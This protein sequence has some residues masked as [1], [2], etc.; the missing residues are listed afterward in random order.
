MSP[1]V[2]VHRAIARAE[3]VLPGTP[4]PEGKRDPRWQAII[5]VG[6]F[7]RTHPDPVW[8]FAHRWGKHARRDLRNAVATCLLEHLLEHHFELVFP[9]VR[10]ASLESV[11]FA[12]TFS[13]CWSF[14]RSIEPKNA[15]RVKR[16]KTQLARARS[17][18][19]RS[20]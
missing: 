12:D 11:R 18:S 20:R 6:E 8:R 4:A 9:R 7:V 19:R 13:S 5:R 17:A 1:E 14:G 15:A 16:L 2:A 3:R 10:R